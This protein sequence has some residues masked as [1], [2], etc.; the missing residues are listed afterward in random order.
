MTLGRSLTIASA[1]GLGAGLVARLLFEVLPEPWGTLANTS[2]LWGLVPFFVALG[3]RARGWRSVTTG[4]LSLALMV[5]A[6]VLLSPVPVAWREVA[7]WA[8]VA[9]IAGALCGVAGSLARNRRPWTHRAALAF[10]GGI[11]AGEA[12][13]GILLIGGPQW[14]FELVI[15]LALPLT[16]GRNWG[17]RLFSVLGASVVACA[18]YGAYLLYDAVAVF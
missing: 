11:V 14:W 1:A 16:L 5:T 3:V 15:G 7:M 4:I 8:V 12:V 2:A 6:W 17:D 9:T 10:I 13:Y 18:L